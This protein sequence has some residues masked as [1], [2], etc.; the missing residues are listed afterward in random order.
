MSVADGKTAIIYADG[1]GAT[2]AKVR[3]I[4]TG[5]DEFERCNY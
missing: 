3:S 1:G 5:S 2:A 4:E